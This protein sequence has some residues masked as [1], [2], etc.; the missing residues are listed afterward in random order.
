MPREEGSRIVDIERLVDMRG[1]KVIVPCLRSRDQV[2]RSSGRLALETEHCIDI[3]LLLRSAECG[4]SNGQGEIRKAYP[5]D[6]KKRTYHSRRIFKLLKLQPLRLLVVLL[7][8][9]SVVTL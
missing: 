9:L 4:P 7:S 8:T 1:Y 2:R 5:E 6:Q 3:C